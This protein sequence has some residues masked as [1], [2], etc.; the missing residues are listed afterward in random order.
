MIP[1]KLARIGDE[2][3]IEDFKCDEKEKSYLSYY[4]TLLGEKILI[5]DVITICNQR[6]VSFRVNNNHC[7]INVSCI[8]SIYGEVLTKRKSLVKK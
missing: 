2:F 6:F 1:L 7:L 4:E 8:G 3:L 5:I